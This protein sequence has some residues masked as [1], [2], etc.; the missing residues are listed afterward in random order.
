MY[1]KSTLLIMTSTLLRRILTF[2][3]FLTYSMLLQAQID[4]PTG[5]NNGNPKPP[6]AGNALAF[7]GVNDFVELPNNAQVNFGTGSFTIEAWVK[8]TDADAVL[9]ETVGNGNQIRL[10]ITGG[11]LEGGITGSSGTIILNGER[12]DNN[13]WTHISLVYNS[14]SSALYVNGVRTETSSTNAGNTNTNASWFI[15]RAAGGGNFFNGQ[16]DEIRIWNRARLEGETRA[17]MC[18]FL[19]P[20]DL[21]YSNLV[22]YFPFDETASQTTALDLINAQTATLNGFDFDG[23]DSGW[24]TSGARIGDYSTFNYG[25]TAISGYNPAETTLN[26]NL[27][28][29][30][31]SGGLPIAIH[32]YYVEGEPNV[33]TMP[34][35][36]TDF[37]GTGYWGVFIVG[38]GSY[39][40]EA[41]YI[42]DPNSINI[43][44]QI[45]LELIFRENN[46]STS[47][48]C[49]AP[50]NITF[51]AN[52]NRIVIRGLTGTELLMAGPPGS[53]PIS[54]LS[55]EVNRHD[56]NS[57]RLNWVTASETDNEYFDLERSADGLSFESIAR[58]DGRGT[59]IERTAY[60]WI[61]TQPL[62]GENYY[63]LKQTDFD[64]TFSYSSVVY[65]D[66]TKAWQV[67]TYPNPTQSK[68]YLRSSEQ[69]SEKVTLGLFNQQGQQVQTWQLAKDSLEYEISLEGLPQGVYFL[70]TFNSAYPL[71]TKIVKY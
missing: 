21:N 65:Y 9:F 44:F 27:S 46:A 52:D 69:L 11:F 62:S 59:T 57:L 24:L 54:L 33:R 14:E 61:D 12:I 6:G 66:F 47:W 1:C 30:I 10:R 71:S 70:K 38:N 32:L 67:S 37:D 64:G 63:R 4:Y 58:I 25:A 5:L 2:I 15:G 49:A 29:A 50:T 60:T 17:R 20:T 48:Q 45:D 16:I 35:C 7:D 34:V 3:I 51:D 23:T 26:D 18:S 42:Y 40:Y 13:K 56:K 55:F 36:V 8:T 31:S 19:K 41:T 22:L 53:L 43:N 68:L 28:V 39:V